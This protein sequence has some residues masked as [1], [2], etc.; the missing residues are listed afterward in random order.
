MKRL[1]FVAAAAA[2][3][4]GSQLHAQ[5]TQQGKKPD[6]ATKKPAA[7]STS[8]PKK[9]AAAPTTAPTKSASAKP[10]DTKKPAT[11]TTKKSARPTTKKDTAAKKP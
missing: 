11:T 6:T 9:S 7:T 4:A 1:Y 10:A 2:L 8:A 3:L 5:V